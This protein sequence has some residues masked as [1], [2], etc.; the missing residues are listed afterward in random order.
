MNNNKINNY[1]PKK[2]MLIPFNDLIYIFQINNYEGTINI[3][4]YKISKN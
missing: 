1:E 4:Q 2:N 3:G